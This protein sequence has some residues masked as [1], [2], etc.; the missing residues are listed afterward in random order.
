[1]KT[2]CFG[3]KKT[4]NNKEKNPEWQPN[5]NDKIKYDDCNNYIKG[6]NLEKQQKLKCKIGNLNKKKLIVFVFVRFVFFFHFRK[7]NK[8]PELTPTFGKQII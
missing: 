3:S 1:M 5:N 6:N 4:F 8:V 7:L 2:K